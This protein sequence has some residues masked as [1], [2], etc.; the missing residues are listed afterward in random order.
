MKVQLEPVKDL[1]GK[2]L[3]AML[4]ETRAHKAAIAAEVDRRTAELREQ[5]NDLEV[6][7]ARLVWSLR[8]VDNKAGDPRSLLL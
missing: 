2:E 8:L 4:A 3:R 7:D 6:L 5:L 1:T